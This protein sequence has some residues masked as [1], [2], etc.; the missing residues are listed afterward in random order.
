N[1][2]AKLLWVWKRTY[3][4]SRGHSGSKKKYIKKCNWTCKVSEQ[5]IG[6]SCTLIVKSYPGTDK[7]LG[8]YTQAH[9]YP[10]GNSN[11]HFVPLPSETQKE[12]ARCL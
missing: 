7:F 11:A 12:I 4:C 10:L 8:R 9:S 1:K 2:D 6:C 3:I 5:Q